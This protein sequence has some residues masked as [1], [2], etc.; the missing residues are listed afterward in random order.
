MKKRRIFFII[1]IVIIGITILGIILTNQKYK[2][3]Q[4]NNIKNENVLKINNS[5]KIKETKEYQGIELSEITMDSKNNECNIYA[6]ITNKTQ[7]L[8][9]N[10]LL[11]V[12]F[13]SKSKENVGIMYMQVDKL[14]AGESKKIIG[15]IDKDYLEAD[16]CYIEF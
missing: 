6:I 3:V 12:N 16:D 10:K 4:Q 11:K 14:E 7:N 1:G 8:I 13:I 9:E 15:T 5:E 2:S